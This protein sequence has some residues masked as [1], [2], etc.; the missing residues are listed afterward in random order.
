MFFFNDVPYHNLSLV[1]MEGSKKRSAW[2]Y[3]VD[4]LTRTGS[5]L[6]PYFQVSKH[7][8]DNAGVIIIHPF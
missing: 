3:F 4:A 2:G 5:D 7:I 6:E 1:R 8:L